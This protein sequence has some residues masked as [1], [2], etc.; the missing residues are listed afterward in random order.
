M[1]EKPISA[2]RQPV[3]KIARGWAYELAKG[4]KEIP[5]EPFAGTLEEA[6][7]R[8]HY[9][10][11]EELEEIAHKVLRAARAE[12]DRSYRGQQLPRIAGEWPVPQ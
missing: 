11:P 6:R 1:T 9:A 10:A 3:E 2:N 4:Q 12:W 5:D 7:G 8:V